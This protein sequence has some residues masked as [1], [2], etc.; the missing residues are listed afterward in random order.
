MTESRGGGAVGSGPLKNNK[1]IGFLKN[2]SLDSLDNH[3]APK[4]VL[5][6]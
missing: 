5:L 4:L 2:T 6:W 3:K 1:N